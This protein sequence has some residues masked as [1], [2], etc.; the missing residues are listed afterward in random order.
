[1]HPIISCHMDNIFKDPMSDIKNGIQTGTCDN[2]TGILSC[3]QLIGIPEIHIEFTND[4]ENSMGGARWVAAHFSSDNTFI[5][6]VDVTEKA[7]RWKSTQFTVENINGIDLK[8]IKKSL[9]KFQGKYKIKEIG[10]E[11]ECWLY[12]REGFSCVEIDICVNGGLHN[13][14]NRAQVADILI[15]SEAIKSI[16]EYV[17][18]KEKKDICEAVI[19]IQARK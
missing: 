18:D 15:A 7:P 9:K 5:I 10:A 17:K 3:A 4:E 1:M 16:V 2:L 19:A 14:H 8:H 6:V 11:S 12:K 13:L